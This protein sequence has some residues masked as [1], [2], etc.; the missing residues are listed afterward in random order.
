MRIAILLATTMLVAACAHQ[1]ERSPEE[2]QQAL[3]QG[4]QIKPSERPPLP[5]SVRASLRPSVLETQQASEQLLAEPRFSVNANAIPAQEF[6]AGLAADSPYNIAVH[7]GVT[8]DITVSL[9]E[10]TLSETLE[11]VGDI[12]GYDIR[13]ENRMIRIFPAGLRTETFALDY[14]A[15]QR[16]GLSQTSVSSGGVKENDRE[17]SMYGGSNNYNNALLGNQGG[18]PGRSNL[19]QQN[20]L[21][22]M[23]TNGSSISTQSETNLWGDLKDIMQGIVGEGDGR[24]VVVSP[25]AG[26]ITITA[27]PSELRAA[28]DFLRSAEERLQRQVILEARI[29]EVALNDNY[30]QGINWSDLFSLGNASGSIGFGGGAVESS[31]GVFGMSLNV[32]DFSGVLNLLQ[33]Q[34]NVQVLSNP[35]VS[36]ANNQKA[37]IKIGEDEYFVTDVSTTTV[38]GT[39]TTSTPNIELTPFFSGISLDIT[40]QIS[41]NGEVILH[42]HPSVVE[43]TEQNKTVTLN[44]ESFVLPLA[45]SNIRES[46]TIVR[47]RNGEIVVLGGLMQTSYSDNESKAP[48]LGD[49]PVVGNLFK[50][51]RRTEQKKELVILIRPVVVG[52]DTW[53]QE[54]ERSSELLKQWYND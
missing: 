51:K 50:N 34:G 31:N 37:V 38:T 21:N 12:Y 44:E 14:L 25:Q 27:L 48:F 33:D 5:E 42:V 47:A 8:G 36:A 9:K 46:D 52:V 40:P 18:V 23:Q 17:N 2:A 28:R 15:L 7:P 20:G 1:P 6:F 11:V 26:L 35:R 29:V 43:T 10:V 32:G 3:N 41:D 13:K 49:I 24:R 4:E 39:A 53:Q 16:M 54:L 19:G 22:G 45:Q 30:Q